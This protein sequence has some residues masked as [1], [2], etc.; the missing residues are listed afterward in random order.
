MQSGDDV[1]ATFQFLLS[2]KNLCCIPLPTSFRT[3]RRS[4]ERSMSN[5]YYFDAMEIEYS[6][7][8]LS[9][10]PNGKLPRGLSMNAIKVLA[11]LLMNMNED[12]IVFCPPDG[13]PNYV[14]DFTTGTYFKE[15]CAAVTSHFGD[16]VYPLCV[17]LN[18]DATDADG[19]HRRSLKPVVLQLKNVKVDLQ[20]SKELIV[21]VGYAPEHILSD[22]ELREY[23]IPSI[24]SAAYRQEA[25][26]YAKR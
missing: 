3:I 17:D 13:D 8:V 6:P 12:D 1:L 5:D 9:R 22:D 18:I 26:R 24:T 23:V 16:D 11:E 2:R 14:T 21:N 10:V 19:L 20:N 15:L 25:V 7:D 4:I